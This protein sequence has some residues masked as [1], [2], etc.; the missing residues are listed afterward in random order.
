M[1]DI[2]STDVDANG[3]NS[4]VIARVQSSGSRKHK[5]SENLVKSRPLTR[6]LDNISDLFPRLLAIDVYSLN[7]VD[8]LGSKVVV[9]I[10]LKQRETHTITLSTVRIASA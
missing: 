4:M 3:D 7:A 9:V 1:G 10:P 5:L 8:V 2:H 6:C